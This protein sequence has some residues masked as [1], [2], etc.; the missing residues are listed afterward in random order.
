MTCY[1][2]YRIRF[3]F[4]VQFPVIHPFV[5]TVREQACGSRR[6]QKLH[7]SVA[8]QRRVPDK[9]ARVQLP[10]AARAADGS[11]RGNG[12]PNESHIADGDDTQGK[13]GTARDR[14]FDGKQIDQQAIQDYRAGE[15]READQVYQKADRL[16]RY[17]YSG[18]FSGTVSNFIRWQFWMISAM[19]FAAEALRDRNS[20]DRAKVAFRLR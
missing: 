20:V 14:C 15:S 19:E 4:V 2:H 3:M 5:I 9:H 16:Y 8:G 13:S 17:G 1:V 6:D 18:I 10:T 7:D 12:E 11:A